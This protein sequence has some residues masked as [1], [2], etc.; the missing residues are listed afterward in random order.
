M[1]I[2]HSRIA[3]TERDVGDIH[4]L[5]A[6]I[7]ARRRTLGLTLAAAAGRCGVSTTLFQRLEHGNG[8]VRVTTVLTILQLLGLDVA[9]RSRDGRPL[10]TEAAAKRRVRR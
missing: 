8:G 2:D 4:E 5:G 6:V 9:V 7:A 10:W 1:E 3:P